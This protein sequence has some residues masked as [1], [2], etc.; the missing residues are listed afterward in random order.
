VAVPALSR[1][2][3][4][5]PQVVLA[6]RGLLEVPDAL[7]PY[8]HRIERQPYISWERLVAA[9]AALD[10]AIAPLAL[11]N[12]FN[13]GK[14]ALKYFESAIVRVPVV[15]SPSEEFRLSIRHGDNGML[16]SS[17]AEWYEGLRSLVTDDTLRSRIGASAW[18]AAG[19]SSLS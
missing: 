6:L 12:S 4:E 16:A 19:V 10:V 18:A 14:S 13:E 9:T 8:M 11:D 15:A 7:L 17:D 3:D 5:S 1:I 2:L